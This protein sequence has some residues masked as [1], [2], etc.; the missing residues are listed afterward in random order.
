MRLPKL[1]RKLWMP[2]VAILILALIAT[3]E[4]REPFVVAA[5][6]GRPPAT[7][8]PAN[9]SNCGPNRCD[10]Y[11]ACPAGFPAT[12]MG[13]DRCNSVCHDNSSNK[14]TCPAGSSRMTPNNTSDKRCMKPRTLKPGCT[15]PT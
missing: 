11:G 2:F 8:P 7:P 6:T 3:I 5:T 1:L 9:R 12:S 14:G 4:L 10:V 13:T 15:R